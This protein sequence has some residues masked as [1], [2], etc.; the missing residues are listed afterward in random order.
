MEYPDYE[1]E[2]EPEPFPWLIVA[3]PIIAAAVWLATFI[4]GVR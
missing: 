2:P 4:L 1:P 3:V